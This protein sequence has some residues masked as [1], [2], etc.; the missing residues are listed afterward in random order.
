VLSSGIVTA[1]SSCFLGFKFGGGGGLDRRVL[2]VEG[3]ESIGNGAMTGAAENFGFADARFMVSLSVC[4]A[5]RLQKNGG[6][7]F[8]YKAILFLASDPETDWT[9]P[10]GICPPIIRTNRHVSLSAALATAALRSSSE[11]MKAYSRIHTRKYDV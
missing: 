7:V 1:A 4:V 3:L 11:S 9:L 10:K 8:F 2:T 6:L 5:G